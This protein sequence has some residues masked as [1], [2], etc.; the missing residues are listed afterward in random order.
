MLMTRAMMAT[1]SCAMPIR[2]PIGD[3]SLQS[4]RLCV[5]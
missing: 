5:Q 2:S 4:A 1:M 3:G